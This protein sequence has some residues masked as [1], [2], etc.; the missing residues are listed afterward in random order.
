MLSHQVVPGLRSVASASAPPWSI[1]VAAGGVVPVR[2]PERRPRQRHADGLRRGQQRDVFR[3]CGHDVIDR[4][5]IE[6][7]RERRAAQRREL[8]HMQLQPEAQRLG[9]LQDA[10]RLGQIERT[11]LTKYVAEERPIGA[12]IVPQLHPT[13]PRRGQHFSHDQVHVGVGPAA[14]LRRHG[15]R[16][17]K[18]RRQ[19]DEVGSLKHGNRI[20]LL[21]L[22]RD[23]EPVAGLGLRGGRAVVQHPIKAAARLRHQCLQRSRACVADGA[24][25]AAAGR[26]DLHVGGAADTHLELRRPVAGPRQVRVRV[27]EAGNDRTPAGIQRRVRLHCR[28]A[29]RRSDP[30]PARDRRPRSSAASSMMPSSRIAAPRRGPGGPANVINWPMLWM[31]RSACMDCSSGTFVALCCTEHCAVYP[32]RGGPNN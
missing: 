27:D 5:R 22:V 26:H 20:Q 14:I 24:D 12:E 16:A 4:H 19:V 28:R 8:V 11:I 21:Q 9:R 3:R 25:D 7:H 1:S 23:I 32:R 29:D 2:Q 31:R 18:G 10:A 13:R 15:V 6:R 30:R 17:Q